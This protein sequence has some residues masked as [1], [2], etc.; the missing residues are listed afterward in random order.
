MN[1]ILLHISSH[2]ICIISSHYNYS[3]NFTDF[4]KSRRCSKRKSLQTILWKI[5]SDFQPI[6]FE[7]FAVY[8]TSN[9]P[10]GNYQQ[11]WHLF[12]VLW[13]FPLCK[14]V[15][16]LR[17]IWEISSKISLYLLEISFSHSLIEFSNWHRQFQMRIKKS[18]NSLIRN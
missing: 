8:K 3:L 13:K 14:Q 15:L 5:F 11:F 7:I 12:V 9:D 4:T 18:K 6:K 16:F 1:A 2:V 17:K 10:T